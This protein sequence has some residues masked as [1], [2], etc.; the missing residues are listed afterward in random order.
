M[1]HTTII[2]LLVR[3][4]LLL[5]GLSNRSASTCSPIARYTYQTAVYMSNNNQNP[6]E[7]KTR[8]HFST[9]H[10]K[11]KRDER[12][13]SAFIGFL[14]R[15]TAFRLGSHGERKEHVSN[16]CAFFACNLLVKL[17]FG[18]HAPFSGENY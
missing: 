4:S 11:K 15:I 14:Q 18:T 12:F 5:L 10:T 13:C 2:L 8:E 16:M 7:N 17:N 6:M 3:S 1:V 9:T